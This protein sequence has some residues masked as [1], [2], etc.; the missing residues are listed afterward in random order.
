MGMSAEPNDKNSVEHQEWD[1]NFN[2][3]IAICYDMV[4]DNEDN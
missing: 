3:L 1:C 4:N 2:E